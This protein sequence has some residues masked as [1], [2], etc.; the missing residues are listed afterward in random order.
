MAT[1]KTLE[2]IGTYA[3]LSAA[4]YG[5][6]MPKKSF[7]RADSG[8]NSIHTIYKIGNNDYDLAKRLIKA[9]P[10]HCKFLRQVPVWVEITAPMDWWAEFDTYKIGTTANSTSTMHTLMKDD[11]TEAF[12][13]PYGIDQDAD[14]AF[15]NYLDAIKSIQL[16]YQKLNEDDNIY[17]K[18]WAAELKIAMKRMLPASFK[19][20]R[21][22]GLNYQVLQNMYRQRK[23]HALP[24]W[25][26]DFVSWI[27]TLPYNEF[28]T[29][30]FED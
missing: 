10:E 22:V 20:T 7:D 4:L 14:S 3:G 29:G 30:E 21:V 2:E 5:M 23:N 12:D 26:T 17:S 15:D 8:W 16:R 25:N 19:Y 9:G 13:F 1:F 18:A 24:E 6:R 27:N 28:I 11:L